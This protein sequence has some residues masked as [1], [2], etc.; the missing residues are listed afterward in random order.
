MHLDKIMDNAWF[1][2]GV[3]AIAFFTNLIYYCCFTLIGKKI[4]YELRYLD[5]FWIILIIFRWRYIRA[6]LRQD[7][8]WFDKQIVEGIPTTIHKNLRDIEVASGR[9]VAF[10]IYSVGTVLS[11]AGITFGAGYTFCF[12]LFAVLVYC[13]VLGGFVEYSFGRV[14]KVSED[15]FHKGGIQAEE[16]I[17]AIKVVKAFGQ[18]ER[19]TK[20]FNFHLENKHDEIMSM[21]WLYGIAFGCLETMCYVAVAYPMLIGCFFV[22]ESV[23]LIILIS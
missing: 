8:S 18:E 2:M 12:T 5:S 16:T 3:A 7:N 1:I 11:G 21:A 19:C 14:A 4:N 20:D 23:S 6:V 15:A 17:S 10:L 9:T 22:S 13:V